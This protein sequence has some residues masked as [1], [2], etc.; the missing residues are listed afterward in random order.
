MS[1]NGCSRWGQPFC[2]QCPRLINIAIIWVF[3]Y[4]H[5]VMFMVKVK[6]FDNG[7]HS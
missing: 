7:N 6:N 4:K 3:D 5:G 1:A 2:C